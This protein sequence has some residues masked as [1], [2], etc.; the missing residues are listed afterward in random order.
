MRKI[1][2]TQRQIEECIRRSL[3]EQTFYVADGQGQT[4]DA[5]ATQAKSDNPNASSDDTVVTPAD[6]VAGGTSLQG[7]NGAMLQIPLKEECG[8]SKKK[9]KAA[10][11][12]KLKENCTIIKKKDLL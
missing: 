12:K 6:T 5:I 10:R 1:H 9:L 4:I 3:E 2:F 11:L 7:S 8:I